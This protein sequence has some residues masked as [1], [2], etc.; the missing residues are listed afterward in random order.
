MKRFDR[1]VYAMFLLVLLADL[2]RAHASV[3]VAGDPAGS[4]I[5][6]T[7]QQLRAGTSG[8]AV[9]AI[10]RSDGSLAPVVHLRSSEQA[11]SAW[12]HYLSGRANPATSPH[13]VLLSAAKLGVAADSVTF[14][15]PQR[16]TSA[17][18]SAVF[19]HTCSPAP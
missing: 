9:L 3:P 2:A 16:Q 15:I 5:L 11:L 8:N 6:T 19:D 10:R 17:A 4:L 13:L 18:S 12:T 1:A 7:V 14:F